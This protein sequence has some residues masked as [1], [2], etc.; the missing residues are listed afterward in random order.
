MGLLSYIRNACL[1]YDAYKKQHP[2]RR[3]EEF[4]RK[5]EKAMGAKFYY[6]VFKNRYKKR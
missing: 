6:A 3:K 2:D 1:R 4:H 5:L